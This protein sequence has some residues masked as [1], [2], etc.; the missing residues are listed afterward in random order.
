MV[1]KVFDDLA[2]VMFEV[3][4]SHGQS[5]EAVAKLEKALSVL[6]SKLK[7]SSTPYFLGSSTFSMVDLYGLPHTSRIFYCKGTSMDKLYQQLN[8]ETRFPAL[9]AWFIRMTTDER[10]VKEALIDPRYFSLWVAELVTL[11]LG[12]KPPL[13]HP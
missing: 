6:E 2:S 13:R 1:M 10:L 3:I 5:T 7:D 12:K 4:I 8:L 9:Y 11:P